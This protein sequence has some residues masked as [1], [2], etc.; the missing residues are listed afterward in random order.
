MRLSGLTV[1]YCVVCVGT[2]GSEEGYRPRLRH[3]DPTQGRHVR[4]RTGGARSSRAR[5]P[6]RG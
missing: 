5:C 6:G 4:E 2:A 3:E 1:Q